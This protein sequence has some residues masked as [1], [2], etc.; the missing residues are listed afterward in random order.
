LTA[1]LPFGH[2]DFAFFKQVSPQEELI[3]ANQLGDEV[4]ELRTKLRLTQDQFGARYKISGPAIFKFEKNYVKPS[5]ELWLR[6][7]RDCGLNERDA[8]MM[9]VRD[10]LPE[11]YRQHLEK[12][13]A[14]EI[15]G[16]SDG[17][18]DQPKYLQFGNREDLRQ[19]VIDDPDVHAG[20]KELATDEDFWVAFKPT[21]LEIHAVGLK[22]GKFGKGKKE[23]FAEALR[24]VRKFFSQ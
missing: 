12:T 17:T 14:K 23:N 21:G 20:L 8:V 16:Q 1:N 22:F 6:I 11:Q 18:A 10:K 9:W 19:A 3:M 4:H 7:A 15:S 2:S 13:P 5:L 24:V